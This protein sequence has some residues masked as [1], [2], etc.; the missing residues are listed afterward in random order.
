MSRQKAATRLRRE[1][2]RTLRKEQRNAAHRDN[3][4]VLPGFGDLET[5]G[6]AREKRDQRTLSPRNEVQRQYMNAIK[7]QNLVLRQGKR[8]VV[9]R[10]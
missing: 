5:I 7:H 8:G 10:F 9:K 3:V 2:K 6:M 4:M 1:N